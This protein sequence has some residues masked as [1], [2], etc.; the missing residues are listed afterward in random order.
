MS[1]LGVQALIGKTL[2]PNY[3]TL[4]S[5][6]VTVVVGNRKIVDSGLVGNSASWQLQDYRLRIRFLNWAMYRFVLRRV[7]LR[8][9]FHNGDKQFSRRG[10]P[11]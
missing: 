8:L 11:I 10:D 9:Y 6:W 3:S 4:L 1:A 2:N 7:T 5:Q